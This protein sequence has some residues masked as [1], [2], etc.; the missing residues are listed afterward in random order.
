MQAKTLLPPNTP[1]IRAS[2]YEFGGNI[3]CSNQERLDKER[4]T[5][6]RVEAYIRM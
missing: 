1:E 6:E 3:V 4:T 2:T 5:W